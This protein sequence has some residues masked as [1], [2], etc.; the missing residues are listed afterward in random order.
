MIHNDRKLPHYAAESGNKDEMVLAII[1]FVSDTFDAPARESQPNLESLASHFVII[2]A[3]I[4][5]YRR[6][7][8]VLQELIARA[9]CRLRSVDRGCSSC[10]TGVLA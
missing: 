5:I 7:S 3:D 2:L 10:V 1:A 6:L 8:N 4:P 9:V